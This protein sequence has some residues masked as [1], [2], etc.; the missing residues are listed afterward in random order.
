MTDA[1]RASRFIV[2]RRII[3]WSRLMPESIRQATRQVRDALY[4]SHSWTRLS[5]LPRCGW[6]PDDLRFGRPRNTYVTTRPGAL[7][8]RATG[9]EKTVRASSAGLPVRVDAHA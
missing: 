1:R 7:S 8:N 4:V 6:L 3:K 9:A 2:D 5:G